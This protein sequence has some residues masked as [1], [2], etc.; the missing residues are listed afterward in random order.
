MKQLLLLIVSFSYGFITCILYIF[1]NKYIKK[2]IVL[3]YLINFIYFTLITITYIYLLFILNRGAIHIYL[4]L[5]LLAGFITGY[6]LS[7]LR[8]TKIFK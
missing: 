2:I 4:K 3:Y 5:M 7:N 6:Y 1:I 8:K